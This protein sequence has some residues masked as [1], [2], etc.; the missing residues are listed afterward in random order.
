MASSSIDRLPTD[1]QAALAVDM[2]IDI[3]T[4]G[5]HSGEP[6]RIEI[7]FLNID[8][9]IYITGTPGPRDWY[10][11]LLADQSLLFHLKETTTADLSAQAMIV[12]DPDERAR[13]F[14]ASS[15]SWYLHQGDSLDSL[16]DDAPMVRVQFVS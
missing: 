12:T 9:A 3:T 14:A 8:G 11:N 13:V 2:I 7:W 4:T 15:A 16:L 6:R 5:R 10:A 1:V